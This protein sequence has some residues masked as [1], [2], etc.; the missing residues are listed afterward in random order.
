MRRLCSGCLRLLLSRPARC[1]PPAPS[2]H[3]R[4]QHTK[5]EI[6]RAAGRPRQL[7]PTQNPLTKVHRPALAPSKT[8][9][10]R[11]SVAQ[12]KP[13]KVN[14]HSKLVVRPAAPEDQQ[15]PTIVLRIPLKVLRLPALPFSPKPRRHLL[16]V[17][18]RYLPLLTRA[19]ITRHSFTASQV[20]VLRFLFQPGARINQAISMLR[21][22]QR[23]GMQRMLLRLYEAIRNMPNKPVEM[24]FAELYTPIDSISES[25]TVTPVQAQP[26]TVRLAATFSSDHDTIDALRTDYHLM[27]REVSAQ[28]GQDLPL[29]D[30]LD[31]LRLPVEQVI[32]PIS[33]A[34]PFAHACNLAEWLGELAVASCLVWRADLH[35]QGK[36]VKQSVT[37]RAR[38]IELTPGEV[39]DALQAVFEEIRRHDGRDKQIRFSDPEYPLSSA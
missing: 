26:T 32:L 9:R 30:F 5:E 34:P 3:V 4:W 14:L 37:Q 10:I 21:T 12:M 23:W 29:Q 16:K 19:N 28:A 15:P 25:S 35:L 20:S 11:E 18:P 24:S 2:L 27:A 33:E 8:R 36:T 1:T 38:V 6:L 22:M 31:T 7:F 17:L 39:H 13:I